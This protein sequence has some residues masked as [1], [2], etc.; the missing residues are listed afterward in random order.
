MPDIS[1]SYRPKPMAMGLAAAFFGVCGL[2]MGNSALT[3]DRGLIID[4]L[5][6][7]DTGGATVF[8]WVIAGLSAAMTLGGILGLVRGL[9][10]DQKLILSETQ[11]RVPKS[12]L[13]NTLVSVNYGDIQGMTVTRVKSQV[14]LVIH[15][16]RGKVTITASMLPNRAAFDEVHRVLSERSGLKIDM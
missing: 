1:Y 16:I 12:G 10:S 7:L 5:I 4:G 2:V 3:T 15:H 6:R 14:F 8:Y 13:S 9:T 11:L